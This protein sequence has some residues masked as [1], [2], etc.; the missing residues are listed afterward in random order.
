MRINK[1]LDRSIFCF[2]GW[3]K[4]AV[5]FTIDDGNLRLDKK[6]ID[7]VRPGGITGSFNLCGLDR[8]GSLTPEEYREFYRGFE[9][10][11]HCKDHPKVIL[12]DDNYELSDEPF[13]MATSDKS[14][15]YRSNTDGLYYKYFTTWWGSVATTDAY[16][17]LI[18]AGKKELESVFGE[19]SV[20]A[21]V[22]P[23][24]RQE[25]ASL[26]EH[27]KAAGYA[28]VRR[29]GTADFDL[30]ADRMDWC[31]NA[32]HTNLNA[33]AAEFDALT[34]DG[35]LKW[36]CFGVH[37]HD[38][39]NNN[40]WDVLESF[41]ENYGNR[42]S[43]FWYATVREIFEYED[44]VNMA[45]ITDTEIINNSDKELYAKIDSEKITVPARTSYKI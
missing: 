12:P 42:P 38:F 13:D 45:E 17:K 7:T 25:D 4:K 30:P 34:D 3:I 33:R 24:R 21:F 14:K 22:W 40:C 32:N 41:V 31:Y 43:D 15:I 20:V 18:D 26:I 6:F 9:V 2:P 1:T 39:E 37:S 27:L 23:Y 11:N 10:T 29:T 44:A 8:M 5:S 36:F 16:I 35:K 28:S 19:G